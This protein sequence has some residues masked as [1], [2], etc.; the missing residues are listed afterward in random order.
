LRLVSDLENFGGRKRGF[1]LFGSLDLV[2]K[3]S[4]SGFDSY[5]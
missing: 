3:Y 5:W 4:I 1:E 2:R